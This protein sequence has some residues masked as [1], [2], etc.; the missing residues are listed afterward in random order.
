MSRQAELLKL[1]KLCHLQANQTRSRATKQ[2][3]HKIG[4]YYQNEA[5]RVSE[6]SK[7][8][9]CLGSSALIALMRSIRDPDFMRHGRNRCHHAVRRAPRAGLCDTL[10]RSNKFGQW[11]CLLGLPISLARRVRTQR[12][13]RQSWLLQSEPGLS[14]WA[15]RKASAPSPLAGSPLALTIAFGGKIERLC[16]FAPNDPSVQRFAATVVLW[17]A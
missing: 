4:D 5:E 9:T 7:R 12:A 14:R 17:L 11:R 8:Q 13:R 1:A 15:A 16:R 6:D 3:L 10:V 2:R